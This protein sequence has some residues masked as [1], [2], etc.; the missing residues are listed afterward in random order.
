MIPINEQGTIVLFS[1]LADELGYHF[2]SI[3]TG[4]PDAILQKDGASVRVEFEHKASNFRL[5]K[6]DPNAVDLIICWEDDWP[7]AA[8]PVLSL[9][10]YV[11]LARP[12]VAKDPWWMRL[13]QWWRNVRIAYHGQM[14]EARVKIA[15]M[16]PICQSAMI[17]RCTYDL[18]S[19]D[20]MLG[21]AR[22]DCPHCSY[23][24]TRQVSFDAC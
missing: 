1:K 4:C 12:D 22:W 6:H 13:F 7:T 21:L 23:V 5:H 2:C 19:D 24:T 17:A 11:T 3:G 15:E 10:H 18:K 8:L 9:S 16:C 14:L 20:E